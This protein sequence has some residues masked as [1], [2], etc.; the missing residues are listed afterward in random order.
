MPRDPYKYY[1]IEARELIDGLAKGVLQIER[2]PATADQSAQLMRI[3][4]TLKGAARVVKQATSAELAHRFEEILEPYRGGGEVP[5]EHSEAMLRITDTLR[6]ELDA[7]GAETPAVAVVAPVIAA[8]PAALPRA[9]VVEEHFQSVR[10]DLAEMD[11]LLAGVSESVVQVSALQRHAEELAANRSTATSIISLLTPEAGSMRGV[12]ASSL[13][14]ARLLL[15]DLQGALERQHRQLTSGLDRS[16][17]ELRQVRDRAD[18]LRLVPAGMVFDRL[19]RAARDAAIASNKDIVFETAGADQRLDGH[20]LSPLA[21]ALLHVVR[22]AA[23]HGIELPAE[24]IAADKPA[25]GRIEL[26]VERRGNRLLF[27]CRDDGRGLDVNAIREAAVRSGK[28]TLAEA[29]VLDQQSAID[30]LMRGGVSTKTAVTEIS[31]RGVGMDVVRAMTDR[32]KGTVA[33][34]STFKQGTEVE[35]SV[36]LSLTALPALVIEAGGLCV[37]LP[38]DAVRRSLRLAQNEIG[39]SPEGETLIYDNN[40]LPLLTLADV[41]GSGGAQRVSR[42]ALT[43]VIVESRG[44][45]AG[46]VVD[47]LI[48][49]SDIVVRPLPA[50]AGTL[51]LVAGA[52]FDAEGDPQLVIDPEGLIEAAR[53]SRT[54]KPL[55]E[56]RRQRHILVVDDSLTTRMLEQSILES[57]G[58][59][60][61]LAVSAE[62]ALELSRHARYDLFVVDVEMPGISGFEF[63]ARTRADSVL[64]ETPAVLVSSLSSDADKRRGA[65]AGASAYIVKGEFDQ[66]GFLRTVRGLVG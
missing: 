20:V 40:V 58:Y 60:V 66:G 44:R 26:R 53:S 25:Q 3:A 14:R 1:R 61:S 21:D 22:N 65:E 11:S 45:L 27:R 64:R 29:A 28:L 5:R 39:R 34:R 37:A 51:P 23:D 6:A 57:A 49:R 56:A 48:G 17:T 16:E 31:G 19:E 10:V 18:A 15:T 38:L 33:V 12:P 7:L 8:A 59:R 42:A 35:I 9:A 30:L 24:R 62:D 52:A 50:A 63:V 36:P 43:V 41:L 13:A 32:L 54:A 2:A 46:I 47:R 55:A 4:H